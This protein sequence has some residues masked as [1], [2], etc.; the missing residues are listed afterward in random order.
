[1]VN[2]KTLVEA[3]RKRGPCCASKSCAGTES[4]SNPSGGTNQAYAVTHSATQVFDN[5]KFPGVFDNFLHI[6]PLRSLTTFVLAE[7]IPA[8]DVGALLSETSAPFFFVRR[9]SRLEGDVL[10]E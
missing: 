4:S 1:M 10:L 2:F 8:A 6:R 9:S 3:I 5:S 7:T